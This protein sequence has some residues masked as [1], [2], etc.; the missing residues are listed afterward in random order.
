[1]GRGF[2]WIGEITNQA[3]FIRFVVPF[4]FRSQVLTLIL[5]FLNF[6]KELFSFSWLLKSKFKVIQWRQMIMKERKGS[7]G[8]TPRRRRLCYFGLVNPH[9]LE[10][11]GRTKWFHRPWRMAY[12]R[13]LTYWSFITNLLIDRPTSCRKRFTGSI[14]NNFLNVIFFFQTAPVQVSKIFS[15][16]FVLRVVL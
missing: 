14:K 9:N 7:C 13:F 3:A 1:M 8:F 16:S 4:V 10:K 11:N 12:N 6:T 5:H 15:K 2:L